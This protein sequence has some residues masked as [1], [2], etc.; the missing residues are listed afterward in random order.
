MSN[1]RNL[2]DIGENYKVKEYDEKIPEKTVRNQKVEKQ[3]VFCFF[4]VMMW[5]RW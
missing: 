3:N 5:R 4:V 1:L 2:Y